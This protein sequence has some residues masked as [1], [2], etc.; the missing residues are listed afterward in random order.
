MN[1]G[2]AGAQMVHSPAAAP[3]HS[4]HEAS[5]AWHMSVLFDPPPEQMKPASI[6]QAVLQPSPETL[7]PSSHV[8]EPTRRPSPQISAHVLLEVSVPPVHA[9]PGS[10]AQALLHPSPD[11]VLP[12]SQ[13]SKRLTR[14]PSPQL[15]EQMSSPPA[16]LPNCAELEQRQ[17]SST[18]HSASQP[19]PPIVLLS[20]HVSLDVRMPLPQ[21]WTTGTNGTSAKSDPVR[22]AGLDS[23]GKRMSDAVESSGSK[24]T[25]AP[26]AAVIV[27]PLKR[28]PSS[29]GHGAGGGGDGG[30]RGGGGSPGG[31]GGSVGWGGGDGGHGDDGG[32]PG[33]AGAAGGDGGSYTKRL[34]VFM[35]ISGWAPT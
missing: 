31:A 16:P 20:S 35:V 24:S 5:Q 25:P 3:A 10:I 1:I 28:R 21:M 29:G 9:Y 26:T 6:L 27:R 19:S 34:S 7:L 18:A 11:S 33:G 17:P 23:T 12:S 32:G 22:L 15:T 8:S 4:A 30:S 13:P 14:K 2:V